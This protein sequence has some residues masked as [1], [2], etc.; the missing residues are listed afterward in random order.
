MMSL[1]ERSITSI[2]FGKC[3]LCGDSGR[4]IIYRSDLEEFEEIECEYCNTKHF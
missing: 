2:V 4:I 3:E 1:L